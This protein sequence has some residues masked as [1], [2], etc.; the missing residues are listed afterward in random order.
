MLLCRCFDGKGRWI[1]KEN[2][3]ILKIITI[4]AFHIAG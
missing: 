3:A 1:L 4:F 2:F